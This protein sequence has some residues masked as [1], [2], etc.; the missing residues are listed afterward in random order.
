[1]STSCRRLLPWFAVA[2]VAV[3]AGCERPPVDTVQRGFR[4]TGMVEVYNPR[5]L[6]L[7]TA[8]NTPPAV[9]PPAESGGPRAGEVFKNVQVLNDLSVAEFT[10]VMAAI[11][12]WVAPKEGCAYCH[13]NGD[14]VTDGTYTKVVARRMLQMTRTING[15]WKSHVGMTGVTCFTC[16]RGQNVPPM[17][18]FTDPGPRTARGMAGNRAGQNFPAPAVGLTSL[19]FDPFTRFLGGNDEIRVISASA[20][21]G[22]NR[23]TIKQ[24]EVTYALMMH[25][26]QSLGV[27]CT[28]CHNTRSFAEWDGS[29]PQRAT[30]WH[31]IRMVRDLNS[32]Y[33]EPLKA[34][35]PANRLGPTG[36]VPKVGCGTCHEGAY[37]PLWGAQMLRDYPELRAGV[38]AAAPALP[39]TS[40]AADFAI[41]YFAVASSSVPADVPDAL[42]VMVL[43]L[44]THP[45]AKAHISG[46]H[47]A[48]GDLAQNQELAKSRALAVQAALKAAGVADAALILEKPVSAEANL[49]GEDPK[50][51]RVEVSLK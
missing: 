12:S 17:A 5:T 21:R 46:Y 38:K 37:K 33:L 4:G 47:S 19:P 6:V 14:F 29:T 34:T 15:D 50:A 28:F 49:A 30:A 41:I 1:M 42:G 48:A 16:H 20:L 39:P 25:I 51:R 35:F 8:L 36:D 11:T 3:T 31:G 9:V 10:R 18:W 2:I 24:T 44:K 23:Q 43:F 40:A 45:G 26:S 13:A 7:Q 27:N 32:E 22:S